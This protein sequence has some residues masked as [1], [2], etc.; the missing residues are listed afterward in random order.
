RD[1]HLFQN[2]PN[3]FNAATTLS[4]TLP[5][6]THV[7]LVVLDLA[8]REVRILANNRMEE[9]KHERVWKASHLPSG[10]YLCRLEAGSFRQTRK[11]ALIK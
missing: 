7:S 11:L 5:Y 6:T 9:G 10:I 1:F 8:G 4:F 2:S 3:P